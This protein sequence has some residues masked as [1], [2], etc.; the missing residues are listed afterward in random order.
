[1]TKPQT[2]ANSRGDTWFR[3]LMS[4]L[5]AHKLT[6]AQTVNLISEALFV[7]ILLGL[8]WKLTAVWIFAALIVVV[9]FA[10]VCL[11]ATMPRKRPPA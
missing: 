6:S 2:K 8:G 4:I 5:P 3:E 10:G 11:F 1:M 7:L 9:A